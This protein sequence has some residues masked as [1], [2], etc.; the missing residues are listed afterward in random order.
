M[1]DTWVGR[2]AVLGAQG[3]LMMDHGHERRVEAQEASRETRTDYGPEEDRASN[4]VGLDM[5]ASSASRGASLSSELRTVRSRLTEQAALGETGS[6]LPDCW[7]S[8]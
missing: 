7:S 2:G 5:S 8:G 1:S 3:G 6:H 4:E